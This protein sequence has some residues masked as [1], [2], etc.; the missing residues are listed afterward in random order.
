MTG[1]VWHGPAL[2]GRGGRPGDLSAGGTEGDASTPPGGVTGG[3][4]RTASLLTVG[5]LVLLTACGQRDPAPF[6]DGLGW[7][8][9]WELELATEDADSSCGAVRCPTA[10]RYYAVGG[11]PAEACADASAVLDVEPRPHERGCTF[12]TCQDDVLVTVSVT[13]DAQRVQEGVDVR[14]VRA[15]P[16]GSAVA[17]RAR[18]GC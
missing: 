9:G 11:A 7:P 10:I 8:D 1:D 13:D 18:V 16:G 12:V 3:A 17:V 15:P 4:H 5:L 6:A 14:R 2:G